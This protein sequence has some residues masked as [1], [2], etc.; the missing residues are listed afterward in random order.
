MIYKIENKQCKKQFFLI[1]NLFL[2]H[3]KMFFKILELM[4]KTLH[5]FT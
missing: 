3:L 1:S 4:F 5:I 2:I